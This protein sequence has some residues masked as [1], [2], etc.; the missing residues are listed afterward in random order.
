MHAGM[1]MIPA[2]LAGMFSKRVV[3]GLVRRL[4]YRRV[5][6]GNT[7][8][9][10][11]AMASFALVRPGLPVWV[12]GVQFAAFGAVNSL[13]FTAMNTLTLRDLDGELASSGNSLLSMVMMLSMSLGVAVAGGLLGAFGGGT[14][15]PEHAETLSA[16]RWSFVCVGVVTVTSAAIFAQLEPTDRLPQAT[17]QEADSL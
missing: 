9:V 13:Q 6:V 4:G 12:H 15:D 1:M 10:G 11:I 5:L 14:V 2:A 7:L 3:V 8:M 16:F 17:V